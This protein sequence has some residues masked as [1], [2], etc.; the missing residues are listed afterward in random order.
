MI[1]REYLSQ[2]EVCLDAC[3][4]SNKCMNGG[5]CQNF[6]SGYRCDCLGT[7]FEGEFCNEG[8]SLPSFEATAD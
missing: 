1:A 8:R 4:P 6:F 2:R 5:K 3:Q 7:G